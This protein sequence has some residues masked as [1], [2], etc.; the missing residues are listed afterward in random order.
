[1]EPSYTRQI[2][3]DWTSLQAHLSDKTPVCVDGESLTIPQ[4]IA[5][6]LYGV[7]PTLTTDTKVHARVQKSVEALDRTLAAGQTV[8]GVNTG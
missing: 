5:V 1:M 6:S 7:K 3:A 2:H 4:V 8:Y